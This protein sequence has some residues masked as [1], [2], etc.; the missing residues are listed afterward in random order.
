MEIIDRIRILELAAGIA[1]DGYTFENKGVYQDRDKSK[2]TYTP[3]N[4]IA[5]YT[6]LTALFNKANTE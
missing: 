4:I 2:N 5:I 3:T 1:N 6:E